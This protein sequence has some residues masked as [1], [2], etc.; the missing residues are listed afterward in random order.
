MDRAPLISAIEDVL[1]QGLDLLNTVEQE[2]FVTRTENGSGSTLGAHYRHVLDHFACLMK[3]LRT[4]TIN[5][6]DRA[7]NPLLETS[8]DYSAVVTASLIEEF[9]SL[10]EDTATRRLDVVY[11]VG[12]GGVA[13]VSV[14][15]T[16]D[17]EIMFC[18][19]HAIHHFAI[20]KLLCANMS[21]AL[22]YEFGVAPSTLKHMQTQAGSA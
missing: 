16:F 13:A 9:R 20:V 4:G 14:P 2:E 21:I 15:T 6:D 17:R 12:Y 8:V 11:S 7:R 19:G 22:P 1:Q 10:P 5:Y 18:V 3:G